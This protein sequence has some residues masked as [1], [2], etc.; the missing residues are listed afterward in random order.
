MF[1]DYCRKIK[2]V[3]CPA[4]VKMNHVEY[5]KTL[6]IDVQNFV[7]ELVRDYYKMNQDAWQAVYKIPYRDYIEMY[8]NDFSNCVDQLLKTPTEIKAR[9]ECGKDKHGFANHCDWCPSYKQ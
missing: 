2:K 5:L 6:P 4:E 3:S 8:G 1:F 7:S 9:C